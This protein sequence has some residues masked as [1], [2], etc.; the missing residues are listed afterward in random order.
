MRNANAKPC[1]GVIS[2]CLFECAGVVQEFHGYCGALR[3]I[4]KRPKLCRVQREADVVARD[5]PK[6]AKCSSMISAFVTQI[7]TMTV[8]WYAWAQ[9]GDRSLPGMQSPK[10][11]SVGWITA[12]LVL[13]IDERMRQGSPKPQCHI[14]GFAR[15][16]ERSSR[17]TGYF[18]VAPSWACLQK[19]RKRLCSLGHSL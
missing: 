6:K 10:V 18:F 2:Q 16:P 14:E 4:R 19:E 15:T 1:P 12:V 8:L 9:A 13:G 7:S 3:N 11:L 5:E 17:V